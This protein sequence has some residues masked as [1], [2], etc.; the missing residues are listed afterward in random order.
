MYNPYTLRAIYLISRNGVNGY[1]SGHIGFCWNDKE[2]CGNDVNEKEFC[3]PMYQ[4]YS[5]QQD[6]YLYSVSD[7]MNRDTYVRQEIICY[8]SVNSLVLYLWSIIYKISYNIH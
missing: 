6:S 7:K 4:Y 2:L 5:S 3:Q 8:V 1:C